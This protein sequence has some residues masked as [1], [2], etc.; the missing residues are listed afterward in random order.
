MLTSIQ[1]GAGRPEVDHATFEEVLG[2]YQAELYCF[3]VQLT[4]DRT[5][6]DDLY[7]ETLLTAFHASDERDRP[8]NERLWLFTIMTDAFL[9]NRH[10][11]GAGPSSGEEQAAEGRGTSP[12]QADRLDAHTLRREVEAFVATLPRQQWVA[13]VQRR[14]LNRGYAEIAET[15]RCSEVEARTSAYEALRA[16]RA[17]VGNRL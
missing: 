17:H 14:Y 9:R 11:H 15:L 4:R 16:I 5:E 10:G 7:R 8:A 3:A 13:L 2:H 6:A 12:V 1:H